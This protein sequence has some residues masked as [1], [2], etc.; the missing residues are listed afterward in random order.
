MSADSRYFGLVPEDNIQ[1]APSFIV[2]P[3][4]ARWGCPAQKPYPWFTLP[5]ILM[6]SL[7][8]LILLT[9]YLIYR[10]NLRKPIFKRLR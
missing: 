7:I 1:G 4:G 5:N 6:W 9:W 3:P 10:N 2:W 8:G